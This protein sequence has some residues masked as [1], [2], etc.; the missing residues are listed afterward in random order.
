MNWKV[1]MKNPTWWATF[2]PAV[3]ILI[4]S[5]AAIFGWSLDLTQISGQVLAI[6]D[7]VFAVLAALGVC[8]D[9]TTEGIGDSERAMMYI[10][11]GRFEEEKTDGDS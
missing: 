2:I 5:V 11:P 7:A 10:A 9:H 8:V 1:R 4:Q 6:I 3:A